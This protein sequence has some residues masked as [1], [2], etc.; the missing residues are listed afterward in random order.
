MWQYFTKLFKSLRKISDKTKTLTS[1]E[2]HFPQIIVFAINTTE[3]GKSQIMI[4]LYRFL[5]RQVIIQ[6]TYV[7][8]SVPDTLFIYRDFF[9]SFT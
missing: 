7:G 6:W 9:V 3:Q 8:G 4:I 2:I 1:Y 5:L